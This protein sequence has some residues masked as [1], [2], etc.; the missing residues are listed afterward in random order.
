MIRKDSPTFGKHVAVELSGEN[1]RQLFIPRGFAHGFIV[2]SPEAVFQYKCDNF[3]APQ[4]EGAIIW[5]DPELAI[6]WR[7]PAD[8][9]ILSGKDKEHPQ[10]KN[11]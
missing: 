1:H 8:K 5:N 2:L 6:D 10:L 3:Y 11:I 7:V 4:Y 9:I